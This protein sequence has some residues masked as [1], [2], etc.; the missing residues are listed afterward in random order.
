MAE[1]E[2]TLK[3]E[4]W[5]KSLCDS[6]S[7]FQKKNACDSYVTSIGPVHFNII[8]PKKSEFYKAIESLYSA[9]LADQT[10]CKFPV[11]Y[12]LD[13]KFIGQ[14]PEFNFLK[15]ELIDI[16]LKSRFSS[17]KNFI[18][19]D[20]ER[21]I[22]K[23]FACERDIYLFFYKD[24]TSLPEWEIYSP[25][26]EFIHIL[27]LKNNCWLAHA[28]SLA[29]DGKGILLFGPGGNGKSTTTIAGI[30]DGLKTVGDDYLLICHEKND[31]IAY[32]VYKIIKS[33]ESELFQL[34]DYFN[35][36]KKYTIKLTGKKVYVCDESVRGAF[37]PSFKIVKNIGVHLIKDTS[38]D[39][40]IPMNYNFNYFSKSTLSQI[41]F[42]LNK[43]TKIAEKIFNSTPKH[44]FT[45]N[46]GIRSL[47]N[48][49]DYI[50]K[51]LE[52]KA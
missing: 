37:V 2:V 40:E 23:I 13:E 17:Q 51:Q 18:H 26:K 4:K 24:F 27:A 20:F 38:V 6:L 36:Y 41:P 15:T 29:K 47:S 11:I 3:L 22:L 30:K 8:I 33:Y 46:K 49:V 32:A 1:E 44:L 42:W 43:S 31:N 5:I 16:Q 50:H 52:V 9:R 39:N 25:L 28:G 12:C 45:F 48:N 7:N 21:G 19:C 35:H 34:P 10:K 14:L